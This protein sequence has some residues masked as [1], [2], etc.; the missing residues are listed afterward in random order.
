ML[1]HEQI[2]KLWTRPAGILSVLCLIAVLLTFGC[3][4]P[5]EQEQAREHFERGK[6]FEE[7]GS[8]RRAR[9]EYTQAIRL[10]RQF[11]EAYVGQGRALLQTN[12]LRAAMASVDQALQ[13]DEDLM[14]AHRPARAKSTCTWEIAKSAILSFTRAVQLDSEY[15]EAYHNRAQVNLED[16]NV[17]SALEDL[18]KVIE[19]KPFE[20]VYYMQR[21]QLYTHLD[22]RDRALRDLERV[23]EVTQDDDLTTTARRMMENI[24][25]AP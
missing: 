9:E 25:Q 18:S 1:Q 16:G 13:L 7:H 12:N 20:A 8:Y 6:Q 2:S 4:G 10:D 5:S 21:A 23:L 17:D 3:F 15:A 19:L 24:R 11:T 22:E 14:E